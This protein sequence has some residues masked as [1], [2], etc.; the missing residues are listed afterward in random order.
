MTKPIVSGLILKR[1]VNDINPVKVLGRWLKIWSLIANFEYYEKCIYYVPKTE[2]L[3][4]VNLINHF[5]NLAL[6]C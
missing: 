3:K 4:T 6:P 2:T 1:Y 5:E